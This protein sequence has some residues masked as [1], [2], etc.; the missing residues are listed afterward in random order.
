MLWAAHRK[1]TSTAAGAAAGSA[2]TSPSTDGAAKRRLSANAR[3]SN[4]SSTPTTPT[5]TTATSFNGTAAAGAAASARETGGSEGSA[6]AGAA[7]VEVKLVQRLEMPAP[8]PSSRRP[9]ASEDRNSEFSLLAELEMYDRSSGGGGAGG[10]GPKPVTSAGVDYGL[11][12]V[13]YLPG[14]VRDGDIMAS[15]YQALAVPDQVGSLAVRA[16]SGT[17]SAVMGSE[18]RRPAVCGPAL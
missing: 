3:G 15:Y 6:G 18:R 17:W 9:A 10:G 16:Q 7:G 12:R 4:G 1:G 13:R 2:T 14:H 8:G 11:L 5:T